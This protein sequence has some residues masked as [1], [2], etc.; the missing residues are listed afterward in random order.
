MTEQSLQPRVEVKSKTCSL[1]L[2]EHL[3]F[4]DCAISDLKVRVMRLVDENNKMKKEFHERIVA[5]TES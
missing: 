4:Y 2:E 3:Q 1:C 5:S